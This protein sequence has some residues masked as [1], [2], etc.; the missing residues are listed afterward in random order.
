MQLEELMGTTKSD[1]KLI[2]KDYKEQHVDMADFDKDKCIEIIEKDLERLEQLEEEN[3]K[4][5]QALEK[6]C[7]RLDDD[8]PVSQELIDDLDCEKCDSNSKECWVKF[9]LKEALKN[10]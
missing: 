2:F 6:A 4:L 5:K 10:E 8:C 9:F 7:E 3:T 1:Q